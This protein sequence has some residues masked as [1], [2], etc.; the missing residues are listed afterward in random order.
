[1]PST[2]DWNPAQLNGLGGSSLFRA[3]CGTFR[4]FATSLTC[5]PVSSQTS[6]YHHIL[7]CIY[8]INNVL[9]RKSC[10]RDYSFIQATSVLSLSSTDDHYSSWQ[11]QRPGFFSSATTSSLSVA[12]SWLMKETVMEMRPEALSRAHVDPADPICEKRTAQ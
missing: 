6:A 2:N 3:S 1:M 10:H 11:F 5:S 7:C 8:N 12:V 4:G 9:G